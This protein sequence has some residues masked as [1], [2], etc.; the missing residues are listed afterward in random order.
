[1]VT[2]CALLF[3]QAACSA[4]DT[5][6]PPAEGVALQVLGSG[7]PVADD[8]RA[9]S[10]YLVW[11]D[12]KSRALIDAGGGGF[13]RFAEAQA[14]FTDLDFVGLSH[15]HADHSADFPA[16]LKSGN[17]SSRDLD[18]SGGLAQL[19]A[20]EIGNDFVNDQNLL[21]EDS[22]LRISAMRVPH[23]IVPAVAFRIDVR[24][25]SIVFSS[26]QNGSDDNFVAFARDATILVMHMP[27][28]EEVD[29]GAR[30]L[31]AVPSEIAAIATAADVKQLVL[32]HFMARS[33]RNLDDN[34]QLVQDGYDGDLRL[35]SD[36]MCTTIQ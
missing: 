36:L 32:S 21:D 5:V 8:A 9:S 14:S 23:G 28:P 10:A 2:A 1:M 25:D 18:G 19:K 22:E 31:H 12:G 35:A 17:F 3:C 27:I 24:G 34:V 15:F 26:D 6:C 13:L 11:V 30:Q 4:T 16:L 20:I 29:D 33:L 7:G